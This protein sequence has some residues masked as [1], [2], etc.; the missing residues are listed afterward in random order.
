VVDGIEN[1]QPA[2]S[3]L[4]QRILIVRDR[5]YPGKPAPG[6]NIPSWDVTLTMCRFFRP[7]IRVTNFVP[8]TLQMQAGERQLWRVSNSS[9][10]TILDL[11][12]VFDGVPRPCSWWPSTVCRSTRRMG[13]SPVS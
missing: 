13:R 1:V 12:Y 8:A 6:G 11:Q 7:E 5:R 4:R 10:D 3:G 9:A 2:V